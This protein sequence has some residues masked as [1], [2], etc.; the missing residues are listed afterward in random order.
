VA[1]AD[2]VSWLVVERGWRV[3]ASGGEDVGKIDETVGDSGRD[4]FNGLVISTGLL[5]RSRYVPA[6]RV[7]EIREGEVRLD[8]APDE[9]DRLDEHR[10]PPPS[11][12]LM[13]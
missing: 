8:L 11:G 6:E 12:Q 1:E 13:P 4:I 5:K 2:P 3:L 10:E 9:V 7:V